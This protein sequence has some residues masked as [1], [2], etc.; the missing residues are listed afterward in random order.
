[1]VDKNFQLTMDTVE[2]K[3]WIDLKEI[4]IECFGV[5]TRSRTKWIQLKKHFETSQF[6]YAR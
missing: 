6:L 3:A 5:K 4:I 2:R 1:M